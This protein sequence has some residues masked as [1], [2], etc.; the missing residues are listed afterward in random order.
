MS[1]PLYVLQFGQ[2]RC[3]RFGCPQVG[4]TFMRGASIP[5]WARRLSRRDF[6][7]FFLGTAMGN[8]GSI[9]RTVLEVVPQP[10]ERGPARVGLVVLVDMRLVVEVLA[11]NGAETGA[12]GAAEDLV[13]EREDQRVAR[14]R[15]QIEAAVDEVRSGQLVGVGARGLVLAQAQRLLDD[16]VAE[17]ANAGAVQSHREAQ[18]EHPAGRGTRDRELGRNCL[19]DGDVP[20]A[21]EHDR[22]DRHV[23]RLAVL[24][25]GP[26][27]N[28][29]EV[30]HRHGASV[31]PGMSP[32][33]EV[34][35]D[36]S[37]P[38]QPPRAGAAAGPGSSS[39]GEWGLGAR[40]IS[41]TAA[42]TIPPPTSVRQPSGSPRTTVPSRT[43]TNGFT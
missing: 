29:A 32:P 24:L 21:A 22:R 18:L 41:A 37:R 13:R 27:S 23:D 7:V 42:S 1:R 6:D 35:E 36:F 30:E 16:G 31:A 14:P 25:P 40:T 20:L 2:T 3:G 26:D 19:R 4:Q 15:R 9:A 34:R 33:A 11:A 28:I 43:A 5:C 38:G 17:A 39:T 10:L 12:V 8:R